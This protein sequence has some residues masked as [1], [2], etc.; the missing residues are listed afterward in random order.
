MGRNEVSRSVDTCPTAFRIKFREPLTDCYIG[1]NNEDYIRE[2]SVTAIIQLVQ[3]TPRGKHSHYRRLARARCHLA[4][5]PQ[6]ARVALS[7]AVL[8]RF[9]SRD[10]DALQ[11]VRPRFL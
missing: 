1:T 7:F 6:E 8:A 5:I 11:E 2:S 3:D 4:R 9:V 10:R